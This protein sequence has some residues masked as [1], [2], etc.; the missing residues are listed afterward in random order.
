MRTRALTSLGAGLA[1][2][3]VAAFQ[4]RELVLL[5]PLALRGRL[6]DDAFF[7]TIVARRLHASGSPSFDGEM[8]TNG[9]QP[10]WTALTLAVQS[11]LPSGDSLAPMLRVSWLLY[12]VFAAALFAYLGRRCAGRGFAAAA[13]A[14]AALVALNPAFQRLAVQGLETPLLLALAPLFLVLSD[15]LAALEPARAL[16]IG[17]TVALALVAAALFFARTDWFWVSV[18]SFAWVWRRG[19][20]RAGAAFALVTALCVAPYLAANLAYGGSLLPISG[21]VKLFYLA[22][23][24]PDL[25]AY[26]ASDEWRGFVSSFAEVFPFGR[27]GAWLA[28]PAVV[29][30]GAYTILRRDRLG[31]GLV[32]F[33]VAA[34]LHFV[35]MH[36]V[37][38]ELR[39]YSGY[40]FALELIWI[41]LLAALALGELAARRP[42]LALGL[43]AG[44]A[45]LS[46]IAALRD[47]RAGD[48]ERY[49]G[50]RIALADDIR[51]IAP[52]GEHVAAF[53]PGAFSY[54]S[55]RD[56]I[57]LDGV[58]G[59]AAYFESH[60]RTGRELDFVRERRAAY[61]AIHLPVPPE[62]LRAQA[63]PPP[64]R[65]WADLGTL[66]LWQQ[67]DVSWRT[68][69]ARTFSER[70][71]GWYLIEFPWRCCR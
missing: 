19:G 34:G 3:L 42:R 27:A 54:F 36:L 20:V 10:G 39:P 1:A 7:Y 12:A 40:Y 21:R 45:L 4:L 48:R 60:V 69:A 66:R 67:R 5:D 44:L 8:T 37:Y 50:T 13:L 31:A 70:G 23:F 52:A 43:A 24:A 22:S 15:R 59:S 41:G 71:G 46:A 9:L 53:W 6:I 26:L 65:S 11:A 62:E 61:L 28:F 55:G 17:A 30:A 58:I 64:I 38:R 33:G 47:D 32:T 25:G 35:F 16:P 68:V 49:W 29:A 2:G 18:V 56:V 63:E 51:R 14:F 57:P